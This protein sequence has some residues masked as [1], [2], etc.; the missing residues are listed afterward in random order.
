MFLID[1][2][3]L[4]LRDRYKAVREINS[5][6]NVLWLY[7]S[8]SEDELRDRCNKLSE[9]HQKDA[10]SDITVFEEG[11]H[12]K[13]IHVACFGKHPLSPIELLNKIYQ[14]GRCGLYPNICIL[15]RIFCTLTVTVASGERRFSK[16][17]IIETENRAT[18]TQERLNGLSMRVIENECA[19]K[20]NYDDIINTFAPDREIER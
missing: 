13:S 20:I 16:L 6:F 12:L 18:L 4:N 5:L 14:N 11:H 19:R 10:S 1:S 9:M 17:N 8:L 3:L 2:L 15:L 7:S